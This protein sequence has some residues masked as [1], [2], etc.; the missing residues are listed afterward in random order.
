VEACGFRD[1]YAELR[2]LGAEVLGVSADAP[3]ALEKWATKMEFPYPLLSDEAHD[4][5]EAWGVWGEKSFL[6]KKFLG[7]GRASFLVG[8]D[9]RIAA[10]WPKVSPPGHAAEVV[11]AL[12]GLAK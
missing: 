11:E 7:V 3:A 2:G 12:R 9:G 8:A 4:T 5:L 1:R 6:G 10:A